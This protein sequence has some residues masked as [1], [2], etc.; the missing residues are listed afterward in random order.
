MV[1]RRILPERVLG[2]R[3][4]VTA[5]LKA[6]TGPILSRTSATSSFSISAGSRVTPDFST[7]KPQG[8]SPFSASLMPMTAH[9][10]TS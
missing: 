5:I 4:T 10:A 3:A 2:R 6:A 9:S 1:P 7:T 8:C